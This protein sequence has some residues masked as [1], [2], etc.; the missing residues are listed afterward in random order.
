MVGIGFGVFSI[1]GWLWAGAKAKSSGVWRA[2]LVWAVVTT[3]LFFSIFMAG[4]DKTSIW[5]GIGSLLLIFTWFGSLIHAFI[6]RNT[7]L[8]EVAAREDELHRISVRHGLAPQPSD[9][10]TAGSPTTTSAQ[11]RAPVTPSPAPL[12]QALQVDMGQYYGQPVGTGSWAPASSAPARPTAQPAP[13]APP[14]SAPS[15]APAQRP[16]QPAEQ[17]PPAMSS[18]PASS[19]PTT[20]VSAP[21]SGP[22]D[23]NTAPAENLLALPALGQAD[24]ERIVA[25]RGERGGFRDMDDLVSAASLQPHQLVALQDRVVFGEF[26]RPGSQGHGR[27]LDL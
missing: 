9:Y 16:P 27:V 8:R 13:A 14:R 1:L 5:N 21:V 18:P 20:P 6:V 2:V 17:R 12:P 7:V 22:V 23:I 15:S 10:L 3:G 11:V 19:S 24:V 26:T 4:S 25:A